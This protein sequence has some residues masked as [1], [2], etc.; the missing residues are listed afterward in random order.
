MQAGSESVS[1]GRV[2]GEPTLK[3]DGSLSV[4]YSNGSRCGSGT[5]SSEVQLVCGPDD[6]RPVLQGTRGPCAFVFVWETAAACG[7]QESSGAD[8]RVRDPLYGYELDVSSLRRRQDYAI[9]L[10]GGRTLYVNLCGPLQRRCA[11]AADQGVCLVDGDNMTGYG[12]ATSLLQY[13]GGVLKLEM[14]GGAAC[15]ASAN[16]ST[17]LVLTCDQA[18][19]AA[20]EVGLVHLGGCTTYLVMPARQACQPR[21][22]SS[23]RTP[24]GRYDLS[25]LTALT[26]NHKY[27][28]VA[29]TYVL[30]VC[31]SVN[32]EEG[33]SCPSDAGSCL[34]RPEQ[35]LAGDRYLSLGVVAG[36]P[37]VEASGAV[38]RYNSSQPCPG[39]PQRRRATL[40][41]FHC[42]RGAAGSQPRL[43]SSDGC[44][45]EF[46][47]DSPLACP[48]AEAR[49]A[50]NC[51]VTN[52][53]TNFRFDLGPLRR[54]QGYTVAHPL[55]RQYQLNVCGPLSQPGNC[56]AGSGVCKTTPVNPSNVWDGGMA[57][58]RLVFDDGVLFLNYSGGAPCGGGG[59][60]YSTVIT[61]ICG[62][63]NA[64][65]QPVVT[66]DD[67]CVITVHWPTHLACETRVDC[68]VDT[69][70]GPVDLT[71]LIRSDGGHATAAAA[72]GA[73]G[74][75]DQFLI[76]VCR[77]LGPDEGHACPPGSGACHVRGTVAQSLGHV[78]GPPRLQSGHVSLLYEHGSPCPEKPGQNLTAELQLYCNAT[79]A[80]TALP[81]RPEYAACR[82]TFG[83]QT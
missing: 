9:P 57:N 30:N 56:S 3:A 68:T 6:G 79:A 45:Y 35:P 49:G 48:L 19:P 36:G 47:W 37:T 63:E 82:Y 51:T 83:W 20:A 11:G 15:G 78:H 24:D 55:G 41:R 44:L 40:I 39:Q 1:L 74:P 50:A 58:D 81:D 21:T 72:A 2:A 43:V 46:A 80:A 18:A 75:P 70:D 65:P 22:T 42:D 7:D 67:L 76:N 53:R 10:D 33:V 5:Y 28:E 34:V 8:C 27:R 31:H 54:P 32:P 59:R 66:D 64:S 17:R 29:A 61:F 73:P 38:L 62:P 26:G 14:T 4:V 60:R 52:P 71:P 77:P 16:H 69:P 25:G 23:C 13:S 12:G